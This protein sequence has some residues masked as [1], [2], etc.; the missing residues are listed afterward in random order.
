MYKNCCWNFLYAVGM[1][2]FILFYFLGK[3][4]VFAGSRRCVTWWRIMRRASRGKQKK[5]PFSCLPIFSR[6]SINFFLNW[7]EGNWV[8]EEI[9][10]HKW[11]IIF[12]H[13]LIVVVIVNLHTMKN[14][15]PS[16]DRLGNWIIKLDFI[17]Y[18]TCFFNFPFIAAPLRLSHSVNCRSIDEFKLRT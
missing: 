12:L 16:N 8:R 18:A 6:L 5:S 15:Q 7:R 14:R 9:E 2:F 1:I 3:V 4:W 13:R 11:K 10:E 17:S